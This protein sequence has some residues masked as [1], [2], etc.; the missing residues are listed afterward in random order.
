M[1]RTLLAGLASVLWIA[2]ASTPAFAYTMDGNLGDWGVGNLFTDPTPDGPTAVYVNG[3]NIKGPNV[4]GGG[5]PTEI[6][7]LE[8]MYFDYDDDSLYFAVV[9]SGTA[10]TG[11]DTDLFLNVGT[12]KF[13]VDF[14]GFHQQNQLVNRTVLG[15][16]VA[17]TYHHGQWNFPLWTKAGD[18]VGQAS[19]FQKNHGWIEPGVAYKQTYVLEGSI[20]WDVLGIAE[21]CKLPVELLYSKVSCLKDTI[22][23]NA[24]CEGNCGEVP[25]PSTMFLLGAGLLGLAKRRSLKRA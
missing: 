11:M 13:A 23:L 21:I 22:V 9:T 4:P 17:N 10:V 16:V 25:E 3:N 19:V 14:G 15:N 24:T 2:I 1:K 8:S 5:A 7:D 18:P 12:D 20:S 6:Y